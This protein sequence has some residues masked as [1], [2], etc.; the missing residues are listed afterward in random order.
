[1]AD[2]DRITNA[3]AAVVAGVAA[4]TWRNYVAHGRAPAPDGRL[5]ATPWWY[6]STVT[7]WA[8]TRPGQGART[9]LKTSQPTDTEETQ[10]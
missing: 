2:T 8:E 9:D 6:R 1:M 7:A 5:G 4:S 3:E 10:P